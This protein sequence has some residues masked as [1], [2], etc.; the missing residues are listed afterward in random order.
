MVEL[1]LQADA[2]VEQ[3]FAEPNHT[4]EE[5]SKEVMKYQRLVD[6]ISYGTQKV[7]ISYLIIYLP[8][9]LFACLS[10]CMFTF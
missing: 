5:Y 9:C 4:F 7:C 6:E 3:F 1:P 2:D 8:D 10:V